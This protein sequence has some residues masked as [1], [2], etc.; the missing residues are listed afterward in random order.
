MISARREFADRASLAAALARDVAGALTSAVS[1]NGSALLAV[2]GGTTPALFFDHLSR[3]PIAWK[4]VTVT[5]VDERCVP[6][7]SERSNARL[8]KKHLLRDE[9]EQARFL[10]LYQ[11]ETVAAALGPFDAVTLGMGSDGHTASFLP[12]GDTLQTALDP[13]GMSRIVHLTPPG[14]EPRLTFSFPALIDSRFLALH[15]EGEEKA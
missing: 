1:R 10:P 7:S 4:V 11:N 15:I 3:E 9:A 14:L 12:G 8:V 5:L 13:Q 6:E 2:S